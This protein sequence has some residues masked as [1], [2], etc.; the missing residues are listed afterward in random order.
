MTEGLEQAAIVWKKMHDKTL[1]LEMR[2]QWE[3]ISMTVGT[4][5]LTFEGISPT[6]MGRILLMN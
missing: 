1:L 4:K 6:T 5:K 3:V 2:G